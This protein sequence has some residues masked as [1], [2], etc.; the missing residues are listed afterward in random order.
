MP[1]D[2]RGTPYYSV[3]ND[4]DENRSDCRYKYAVDIDAGY[5]MST[6]STEQPSADHRPN[7]AENDV[8]E[9]PFA[10]MIHDFAADKSGNQS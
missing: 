2:L 1:P 9:H 6:K 10:R 4:K 7:D 8:Q 3:V 5:T